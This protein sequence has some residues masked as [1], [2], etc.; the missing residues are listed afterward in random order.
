MISSPYKNTATLI[1]AEATF[2][3][4]H[5]AFG[6]YITVCIVS[7]TPAALDV[8]G[9]LDKQDTEAFLPGNRHFFWGGEENAG[10]QVHTQ[11]LTPKGWSPKYCRIVPLHYFCFFGFHIWQH[12]C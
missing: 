7:V 3:C 12:I 10:T 8:M 11:R 5:Q 9:F 4:V 6:Q 1:I 2:L